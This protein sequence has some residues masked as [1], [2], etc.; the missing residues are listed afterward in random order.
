M[1]TR[2][3]CCFDG[4]TLQAEQK[5]WRKG[6]LSWRHIAFTETGLFSPRKRE[7]LLAQLP[8][9]TAAR[10]SRCADYFLVRLPVG[11]RLR[12]LPEFAENIAFLDIETTG[13]DDHADLTVIGLYWH[14]QMQ[15][16]ITGQNLHEFIKIWGQIGVLVTFNGSRFDVPVIMRRLGFSIH[17]PHIDL[18][19]EAKHWGLTGGLKRIERQ[20]GICRESKEEGTGEDAVAL[21]RQYITEGDSKALDRLLSYNTRDVRSLPILAR[22]IWEQSC[23]GC[24]NPRPIFP[25]FE[26]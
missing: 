16:F 26:N 14:G 25:L 19:D 3:L 2:S 10:E 17:P 13:L 12:I 15:S 20:L 5:L 24:P 23:A 18:L 22:C 9:L 6:C 4:L 8:Y 1:L 7:Q 21:W 11:H